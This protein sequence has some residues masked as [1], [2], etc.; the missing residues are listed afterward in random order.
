MADTAG[1]EEGI[2]PPSRSSVSDDHP[3][4]LLP[5]PSFGIPASRPYTS[6]TMASALTY[7]DLDAEVPCPP[8]RS[9]QHH[10]DSQVSIRTGHTQQQELPVGPALETVPQTPQTSLTFLLVSGR[11][12]TMTFEPDTTVGRVKELVWNAW[13]SGEYFFRLSC[14]CFGFA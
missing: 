11:R 12:R 1:Q 7:V 9:S 14:A 5:P 10:N 3:T 2:S 8:S 6:A 13:P 4:M